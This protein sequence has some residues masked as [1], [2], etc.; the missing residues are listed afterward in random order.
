LQTTH[1][2][3]PAGDLKKYRPNIMKTLKDLF[4]EELSD[5]Y[6]AEHRMVKSLPNLIAAATCGE[7]KSALESHLHE[8]EG[9]VEK[10]ERVFAAFGEKPER[11]KCP[12]MAGLVDE[13]DDIVSENKKS[14]NINAAIIAAAQK[15]EHYEIASYGCLQAWAALLGD[16]EAAD[17]LEEILEEEKS[18]DK[19]LNE[20]SVAKNEE[21]LEEAIGG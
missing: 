7:L 8:T 20:I 2:E 10:L 17:I 21:A 9:Q 14:P 18:A 15:I 5:I 13:A 11:H 16:R 19:T 3:F 4:L 12:A 1:P 6:D